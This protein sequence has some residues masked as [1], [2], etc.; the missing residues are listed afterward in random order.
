[1]ALW[2]GDYSLSWTWNRL[3]KYLSYIYKIAMPKIEMMKKK[4]ERTVAEMKDRIINNV[5]Y[6]D[7][8]LK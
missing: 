1:M 4:N 8:H 7:W 2:I 5:H 6:L 3:T